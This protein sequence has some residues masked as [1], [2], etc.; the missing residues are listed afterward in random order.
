[1]RTITVTITITITIAI[2][3]T[4]TITIAIITQGEVEIIKSL[5]HSTLPHLL[6][7]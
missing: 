5:A 3:I 2:A 1:L 4:I 6:A 7:W